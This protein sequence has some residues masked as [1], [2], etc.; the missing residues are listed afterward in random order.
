MKFLVCDDSPEFFLE[1]AKGLGFEIIYRPEI[2]NADLASFHGKYEAILIKS[3]L[4]LDEAYFAENPAL[5]LIFR[6]GSGLD[7]VNL[8]A[9]EKT[10]VKIINS[11][12]GNCNA[13]GEHALGM[14]LSMMNHL[15]RAHQEVLRTKWV[16]EENR[17]EEL[18]GK[19]V[20]IIGVGNT[21]TA[22]FNK[23]RGFNVKMLPHDLYKPYISSVNHRSVSLEAVFE[24][25]DIVSLHLP[26]NKETKYFADAEFFKSFRKPIYFINASRGKV[27]HTESLLEA[28]RSG[29]VKS[30][31]LDVLET[32]PIAKHDTGKM[33]ALKEL[34]DSGKVFFSPHI[35]GWTHEAKEKMFS[36]LLHK[37]R[38]AKK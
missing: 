11:P 37:F 22:F 20:A 26:L 13:V 16:R 21:G 36:I 10:S 30:A 1:E 28:I 6:P 38:F 3:A 31:A 29:K 15:N 23:L 9:A 7:N 32:E 14:L 4:L 33:G 27:C 5:K 34:M 17:G 18:E 12:E 35:A 8:S 19:N 24:K 25:A 2:G